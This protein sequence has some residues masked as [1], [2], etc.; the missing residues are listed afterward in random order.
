MRLAIRFVRSPTPP[1]SY[2]HRVFL[3]PINFTA[4]MLDA[5]VSVL[6]T[7]RPAYNAL[8]DMDTLSR[9]VDG[10]KFESFLKGISK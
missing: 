6:R 8:Q 1:V 3:A 10:I 4:Y 5:T 7:L 9:L 2:C